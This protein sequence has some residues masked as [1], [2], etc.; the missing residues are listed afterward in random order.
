MKKY[1]LIGVLA[2]LFLV[3]WINK[4]SF[5]LEVKNMTLVDVFQKEHQ[6]LNA[7]P[8]LVNMWATDCVACIKEM[9]KLKALHKKYSDKGFRVVAIALA[10]DKLEAI[11]IYAKQNSLN[12]PVIY[13]EGE[14]IAPLFGKIRVTPTSFLLDSKGKVVRKAIGEPEW[15]DWEQQIRQLL[16]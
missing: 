13:D 14:K 11:K 6:L 7:S 2:V 5:S 16:S 10:Y 9:P 12:F 4:E 8:V 15:D 3:V 1:F